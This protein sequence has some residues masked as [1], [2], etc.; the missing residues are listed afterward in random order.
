MWRHRIAA[1]VSL[2]DRL[3]LAALAAG[4]TASVVLLGD[5]WFRGVHVANTWLFAL[6]SLAFWYGISRLVVGWI[7]YLRISRPAAIPAPPGRRVAIFTTSSPGEPPEMF[8]R[9]LAACARV[10]YPHTTYLLDDTRNPVFREMAERH[11]AVWLELVGIPGAKAGKINRALALTDEEFI[12]VLDPDHIP[13][14]EFFDRV[15]GHFADTRVGFVQVCQAYYNQS[16]SFTAAAAAEQTYAFYGPVMM[17][18]HGHGASVAIGA[19]CTFRRQA[20][21]SIGGHGIGLAEDLVTAIR[22]HAAGWRSVYVPEIVSRGL[23]PEDVG[24]FYKQQ[25]KWSRG[26]YEVAFSELPRLWRHLTWR[27]RLSYLTIGTYYLCGISTA[28]FL[29]FPYLY[30]WTGIQ[31]ASMHFAGFLTAASPVAFFGITS[32][33]YVQRWLCD[34]DGERGL[35]WRGLSLKIACWPVYFAGTLL[36]IFRAEIPYVPT[37]KEAVRG[38]FLRLAW[39]QLLMAA[40]YVATLVRITSQR[41][42]TET[43][44]LSLAPEATW[45]MAAFATLP[46]IA[47][48]G[49]L[50]AARESTRPPRQRPWTSID[51]TRIGGLP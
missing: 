12:L 45:G 35:H 47:G 46:V 48:A 11:G 30:L 18:L 10:A 13:F 9:T 50:Y 24:S 15:L 41:L 23:V 22:L 42:L 43:V 51:V 39:P 21:E 37:A 7:N 27:Q 28:V 49:A 14:P 19:N 36:A 26:V 6:L 40:L 2:R 29:M 32:Y 8:E 34:P 4:G 3:I 33:L 25:M 44:S 16:R 5:W 17:G 31:P 38:R 20:L 1:D